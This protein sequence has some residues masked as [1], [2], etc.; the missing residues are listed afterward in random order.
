MRGE[1]F[2]FARSN[3]L[4]ESALDSLPAPSVPAPRYLRWAD[5]ELLELKKHCILIEASSGSW[6]ALSP[7]Q[8]RVED[9]K[10]LLGE[11][12]SMSEELAGF[13][14][15]RN[16][17]TND[18]GISFYPP[19]VETEVGRN[20]PVRYLFVIEATERCNLACLY[21]F[22]SASARGINMTK[23]LAEIVASYICTFS[24]RPVTV[25][26]SGGEPSLNLRTVDVIA[27][28]V[29]RCLPGVRFSL[30]TNASLV[31]DELIRI[32][33]R[34]R[35][36]VGSSLEGSLEDLRRLRPY[37]SGSDASEKILTGIR[38]LKK[39]GLL[40]GVVSVFSERLLGEPA[41][42]LKLLQSVGATSLKLNLCAPLGR[43]A[44]FDADTAETQRRYREFIGQ[45]TA[46]GF[47]RSPPIREGNTACLADRI[48]GRIPEYRCMNS[49]CDAGYT[50]QNIRANGEIYACDRYS[51]IAG[52]RLGNV[53]KLAAADYDGRG[54]DS[55][56]ERRNGALITDGSIPYKLGKRSVRSIKA[57]SRCP[58]RSFCGCGCG[59]ESF[60]RFGSFDQPSAQCGFFRGY[61]PQVFDWVIGS[62]Q[63]KAAY[64]PSGCER[65][66]LQLD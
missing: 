9:A 21:C 54:C 7:P 28:K 5:L 6:V 66:S 14:F 20:L 4:Y 25:E 29:A 27:S 16:M 53:A 10:A 38:R 52:M 40:G 8:R 35:I 32:A 56:I 12:E 44:R 45:L 42:L 57:C 22:K 18:A 17:L 59:M 37:P 46:E 50:F 60:C 1:L 58:V 36:V 49:P 30:Q 64:Y 24:G 41:D 2:W 62:D 61:I 65:H 63:F 47:S 26:F 55:D 15:R 13:L 23:G 3:D 34:H 39:E 33:R 51:R 11:P 43:G 48:L 19:T 31:G